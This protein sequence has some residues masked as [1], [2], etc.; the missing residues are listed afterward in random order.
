M[1]LG[2]NYSIMRD[3][4]SGRRFAVAMQLRATGRKLYRVMDIEREERPF[5]LQEG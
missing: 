3:E 5:M 1:L 4:H 2:A